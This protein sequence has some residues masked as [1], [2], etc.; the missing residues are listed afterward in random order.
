MNRDESGQPVRCWIS[1]ST[2]DIASRPARGCP[3]VHV[4]YLYNKIINLSLEHIRLFVSGQWQLA[5]GNW[6]QRVG[7]V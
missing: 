4:R 3:S 2:S 1:R 7:F 6:Q 5:T